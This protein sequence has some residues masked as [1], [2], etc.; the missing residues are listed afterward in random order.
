MVSR[1]SEPIVDYQV[2]VTVPHG[3]SREMATALPGLSWYCLHLP[4][5]FF[6]LTDLSYSFLKN[7]EGFALGHQFSL[8]PFRY[9]IR[10]WVAA[11]R[12]TRV[13]AL[14]GRSA[15]RSKFEGSGLGVPSSGR[16]VFLSF[17]SSL[18]A[19][20][21]AIH[22]AVGSDVP[23]LGHELTLTRRLDFCATARWLRRQVRHD[24]TEDEIGQPS[25]MIHRAQLAQA[26]LAAFAN[27][28]R[29]G[30]APISESQLH[31]ALVS[32]YARLRVPVTIG[33][34]GIATAYSRKTYPASVRRR[35]Q[36]IPATDEQDT[37]SPGMRTDLMNPWRG[38]R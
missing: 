27:F 18:K 9:S 11:R 37:W 20:W 14:P 13:G 31:E 2:F 8:R 22:E 10:I 6:Q 21:R 35:I 38:Q 34:P 29:E 12:H 3:L 19:H 30:S 4:N 15:G 1:G 7:T 33:L 36:P 16:I 5:A 25:E 17:D 26:Y 24:S 23:Y 32:E 28:E